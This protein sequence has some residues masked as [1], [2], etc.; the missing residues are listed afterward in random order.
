MARPVGSKN[1]SYRKHCRRGHLLS[2]QGRYEGGQCVACVKENAASWVKNNP[3]RRKE[4]WSRWLSENLEQ[5]VAYGREKNLK[6]SGWSSALFEKVLEEQDGRCAL[7]GEPFTDDNM[8]CA[9]HE[10]VDPPRPRGLLHRKCN[11]AIGFLKDSPELCEA[12]ASYL[13]KWK[14]LTQE[15]SECRNL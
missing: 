10:H 1:S 11:S 7:C 8:P 13:R 9:D 5:Q 2:E 6:R 15:N 4:N 14:Q 12:G 3:Q